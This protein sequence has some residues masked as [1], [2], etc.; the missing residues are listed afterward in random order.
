MSDTSDESNSPVR[1]VTTTSVR[2]SIIRE[3][4]EIVTRRPKY[5]KTSVDKKEILIKCYEDGE[6]IADSAKI[7]G[8][9]KKTASSIICRYKKDG[10]IIVNQNRGGKRN[11]KLNNNI[12]EKIEKLVEE[13]PCIKLKN[14]SEKIRESGVQ[15]SLTSINNALKKLRITLKCASINIEQL[16]SPETIQKRK[17]YAIN[18]TDHAPQAREKIIF[19]DESGFNYHMRPTKAR[20][21]ANT[22]AY[23]ILPTVRGRN[24]SLLAAMNIQG[25][26]FKKII[27]TS[28]VNSDIFCGFLEELINKLQEENITN[29]WLILDNAA[30]HKTQKVLNIMNKTNHTLIFLSPY[31][32]MLNPIEKVFSKTKFKARELLADPLNNQNLVSIIEESMRAI[33][34]GDCSNYFL[35][36]TMKLPSAV[37][38]QPLH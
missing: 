33:T 10:N 20:S 25:I 36:M 3:D 26:L 8:V 11:F 28:S 19:I 37:S 1:R 15:L 34:P 31:S 9:N 13:N 14:I 2:R 29:A 12:L 5:N 18:F 30:I 22:S 16:N 7:A 35:D 24:V 4:T 21:K 32:P 17:L 6:S 38:G 27:S 23:I